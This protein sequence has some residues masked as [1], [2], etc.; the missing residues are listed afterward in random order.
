MNRKEAMDMVKK[1]KNECDTHKRCNIRCPFYYQP[2]RFCF[3]DA[4]PID[5]DIPEE[6]G[7][8]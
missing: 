1:I 5:W 3:F 6:G 7:E 4:Q 8:T 2:T